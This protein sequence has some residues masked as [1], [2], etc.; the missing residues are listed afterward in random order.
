MRSY[1]ISRCVQPPGSR[2]LISFL[3]TRSS[4]SLEGPA[5]TSLPRV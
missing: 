4:G 2:C 5:Q 1:L 3:L